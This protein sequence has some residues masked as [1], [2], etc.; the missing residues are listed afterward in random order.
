MAVKRILFA[1]YPT[2][3]DW[4]H[5]IAL[6]SAL[7][8]SRDIETGLILLQYVDDFLD[9]INRQEYNYICFSCVSLQ[10]YCYSLPFID[11]AVKCG[12]AV[13]LGGVYAARFKPKLNGVRVCTGD[14]ELLPM[15][16]NYG[17]DNVLNNYICKDLE[18]LPLP[19]YNLF[20]G[21]PYNRELPW[22]SADT[23][24]L[25]YAS[26]RGCPYRCNFCTVH[27]QQPQYQRIRYKVGE[28]LAAL[29]KRYNPDMIAMGDSLPPYHD[30]KWRDSWGSVSH[31]F[32]SYIRADIKES[33]LIWMYDH[34]LAACF[35]G[36]ES[37]NEAY[38]NQ[39]LG[40]NL[41]NKDI[42]RTVGLLKEMGVTV[43]W[44][45]QYKPMRTWQR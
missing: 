4:N 44:R 7:C 11:V 43:L 39:V 8:R 2:Y 42:M 3:V 20:A 13:L 26:S 1:F 5:G 37:G 10:D 29:I 16:I 15:F 21:I 35:F 36:V 41:L 14:G 28:D 22:F 38:R 24:Y 6:L 12:K 32:V 25:F 33:E 19:D 27:Y 31:P 23:K 17:T 45:A 34:G 30:E 18:S 40:K 9:K